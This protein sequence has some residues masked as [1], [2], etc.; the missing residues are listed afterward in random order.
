M[1]PGHDWPSVVFGLHSMVEKTGSTCRSFGIHQTKC[2]P[3][4][5]MR[6]SSFFAQAVDDSSSKTT[7]L[8][9][10]PA[11]LHSEG[12]EQATLA[13]STYGPSRSAV[14]ARL[15]APNGVV[16]VIGPAKAVSD[17]GCPEPGRNTRPVG[18]DLAADAKPAEKRQLLPAKSVFLHAK[19]GKRAKMFYRWAS[20]L[21][22]GCGQAHSHGGHSGSVPTQFCCSQKTF[23][24]HIIKTKTLPPWKCIITPQTLKHGLGVGRGGWRA[25]RLA[26]SDLQW[27]VSWPVTH[28]WLLAKAFCFVTTVRRLMARRSRPNARSFCSHLG[29]VQHQR[30]VLKAGLRSRR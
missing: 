23:F 8:F 25:M 16:G 5:F 2:F 9:D 15:G 6:C 18:A 26:G 22:R 11:K 13:F 1:L 29:K 14:H 24:K 17:Q 19:S 27:A 7:S 21:P 3:S 12:P 28:M 4:I 30:S 20:F 10:S